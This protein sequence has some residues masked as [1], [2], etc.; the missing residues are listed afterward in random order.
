MKK[1]K[2]AFLI[3]LVCILNILTPAKV[4]AYAEY[5]ANSDYNRML[6]NTACVELPQNPVSKKSLLF[7][8]AL[9][10]FSST[11]KAVIKPSDILTKEEALSIILNSAGRQ[12]DAFVR[13]EKLE[14][15]RPSGSKLVKPYNYLYLGYIQLAYDLKIISKKEYQDA[16]AQVQP[17]FK[18]HQK[19]TED[20]IKKNN[21]IV[22]KA[23]YEG[24]PYSYDDLVFVRSAPAT[25]Q[26]VCRWV[27][28]T[29]RIPQ[30]YENLAR[31]YPDYDKIDSK[32]LSSINTLLKNGAIVGR[33]DGYLHPDDY[34]TYEEIGFILYNLK[35]YI[36]KANGLKKEAAEINGIQR[37]PDKM[38]ITCENDSGDDIS[39]LLFPP[40]QDF[41]VIT[42]QK[43]ALASLLQQGDYVELYVN[44][45]N[46]VVLAEVLSKAGT[47]SAKGVITKIDSKK[48]T[49]QI[50]LSD[51]KIYN[52][53][54]SP[55]ATIY[56]TRLQKMVKLSDLSAGNMVEATF[57]KERLDSL[58]IL[59]YQDQDINRV[60]GTI[61]LISNDR[62]ILNTNGKPVSFLLSPDT[63]Y[64][65]RGDFTRVLSRNDFYQGMK[66][67]VGQYCGYAQYI[68]TT[69]DERAEDVAYGILYEID[70]NL[71]YVEIYNQDGVKKSYRFSKKLGL[72]VIKDGRAA[73]LNDLSQGDIVYLYFNGDFIRSITARTNSQTKIAKIENLKKDPLTGVPQKIYL[74]IDGRVYG[75]YDLGDDVEVV[76]DG[77]K[78]GLKDLSPGQFVK[79]T[80]SFFGM[81]ANIKK[82]E[83]STNEYV[84]NIYLAKVSIIGG[85]LY[86]SDVSILRN[87]K[88][89]KLYDYR[90][91]KIPSDAVFVVD[92]K[93]QSGNFSLQ[94]FSAVVITKDRFSQ[95]V[96]GMIFA[97]SKGAYSAVYGEITGKSADAVF[98]Q[99]EWYNLNQ[100]SCIVSNGL[101]SNASLKS[102]DEIIA[103][104]D[105]KN[106]I[107][108]KYREAVSKPIIVRGEVLEISDLEYIKLKNYVYLDKQNG[109]QFVSTPVVFSY[110]TQT[111]FCDVYGLNS[112]KDIPGL[113][114]K[115]VYIV[116]D[117]KYAKTIIDASFGGYIVV[118]TVGKNG[119]LVNPQYHDMITKTWNKITTNPVLD[120]SGAVLID[121][122]GEIAQVL[123]QYGDEVILLVSQSD[124][125]LNKAT[126]KPSVVIVNY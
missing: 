74:N 69:F 11:N 14:Q 118:G 91:F 76:K 5:T 120:L 59:S 100:N 79:V 84:K 125:D 108:A 46:Q 102:G 9:G 103:V 119:Q 31:L 41:V 36:L 117:G 94:N 52:L 113:L 19:M 110:D 28:L 50:K 21:E 39:I 83:I 40:K 99:G 13:A 49:I 27:V 121:A 1:V 81:S 96:P 43:A 38:V 26:E 82:I 60:Q 93:R 32:F 6:K 18:E 112:P 61:S 75:P 95:E 80:G 47:V 101:L 2:I 67:L 37:Y 98:L 87:N 115:S 86:L 12:Q 25:R 35:D 10:F 45:K 106:L 89:E 58:I 22:S 55:K 90:R 78:A 7:L 72:K 33:S 109:W 114:N 122:S 4:K 63:V 111:V 16:M 29:F 24:R 124:F 66:V 70:A 15:K 123:P 53:Q 62:I 17:G 116:H 126:L 57:K 97:L 68:S 73:S 64:I 30:S 107:V 92:G 77:R 8:S 88:F 20:L 56:D 51:G 34:I 48:N 104:T 105:G 85:D 44:N 23:V 3:A 71:S 65:D 54:V 42:D